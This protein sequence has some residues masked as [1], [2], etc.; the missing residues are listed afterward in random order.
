MNL[1]EADFYRW[2]REQSQ[3][4]GDREWEKLDIECLVEE[5]VELGNRHEQ[6]LESRL[7]I[8][9]AHLLKWQF[10]AERRSNSWQA[11][12]R[13]QRRGTKRLLDK[14]PS[15]KS[16]LPEAFAIGYEDGLDLAVKETNLSFDTFPLECPYSLEQ[17]LNNN[18]LPK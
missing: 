14:N 17:V 7:R 12:I 13:E 15:L 5:L 4:L 1:Y 18:F 10:Q 3:F 2:T 11:T 16:Y 6:Q 9:L 8:L